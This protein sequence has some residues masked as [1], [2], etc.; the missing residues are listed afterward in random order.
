[1]ISHIVEYQCQYSSQVMKKHKSWYDGRLKYFK[2]NS[3]FM[4][5]SEDNVQ[6]GSAFV[7]SERQVQQFLDPA[8]F[9]CQEHKIFGAFVVVI[10]EVLKEYD[11]EIQH[12]TARDTRA[13]KPSANCNA[14]GE[15]PRAKCAVRPTL[16]KRVLI[17]TSTEREGYT[18]TGLALKWN[19]PFKPPRMVPRDSGN[20]PAVRDSR[21]KREVGTTTKMRST[22]AEVVDTPAAP[23]KHKNKAIHTTTVQIQTDRSTPRPTAYIK[24]ARK[25]VHDTHFRSRNFAPI[26]RIAH[27][28]IVLPK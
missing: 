1:M 23:P 20:R 7:T 3:R 8:G 14:T 22:P 5:Y 21:V 19:K 2:A 17:D 25:A 28:P 10:Y 26:R 15:A 27:N 24:T 18:T 9:E 12:I 16:K 13:A 6:L 11:R 4:L